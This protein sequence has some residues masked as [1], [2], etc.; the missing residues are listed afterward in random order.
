MAEL[1]PGAKARTVVVGVVNMR[2]LLKLFSSRNR[3]TTEMV[4]RLGG[5]TA[6][7]MLLPRTQAEGMEEI[8]RDMLAIYD[9]ARTCYP[10]LAAQLTALKNTGAELGSEFEPVFG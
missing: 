7:Q 2:R 3:K 1:Y 4:V 8:D 5:K 10:V 9:H 6:L